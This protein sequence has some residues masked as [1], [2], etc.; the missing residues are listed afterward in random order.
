MVQFL[1]TTM[2]GG[3]LFLV[4]FIILI[5]IIGKALSIMGK[6]AAPLAEKL[7]VDSVA[8][9]AV[10]DFLAI[11]IMVLICFLAGLAARTA[12]ARRFVHSLESKVLS[13]IP[14]YEFLK[15]KVHA[16]IQTDDA[17][18]LKP[19]LARYD[20][21][22]QIGFEVERVEGGLVTVF[23]PG[24]PDPWSGSVCFMT[25]DRVTPLDQNMQSAVIALKG[26]GKGLNVRLQGQ[27]G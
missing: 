27:P 1:K 7:P 22:W 12:R 26:L 9:V 16:V 11:I 20:D 23:L 3:I 4:P 25:A 18:G 6:L 14:A 5:A 2:I 21:A 8:G 19:V 17:E 15:S 10:I 13:K 24:S